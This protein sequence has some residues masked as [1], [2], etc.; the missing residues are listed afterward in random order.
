MIRSRLS[1]NTHIFKKRPLNGLLY[2]SRP[3]HLVEAS[4]RHGSLIPISPSLED[5]ELE[6]LHKTS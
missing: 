4:P 3:M 5:L 6:A 2:I 1:P